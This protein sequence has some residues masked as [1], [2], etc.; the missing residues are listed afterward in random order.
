MYNTA[1][2]VGLV[3]KRVRQK[4]R[5]QETRALCGLSAL[6]LLLSGSLV[7]TVGTLTGTGHAAVLSIYGAILLRAAVGGYVLVGVTAF[8]AAVVI[9]VLCIKY[10]DRKKE[11]SVKE[12]KSV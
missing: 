9:T 7:G 12:D 10:K 11:G 2:R 8:T 3:E 6:C 1:V 5:R 4:R